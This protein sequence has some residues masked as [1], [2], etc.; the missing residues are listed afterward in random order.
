MEYSFD[1]MITETPRSWISG[2]V[3]YQISPMA[4][5]A[6]PRRKLGIALSVAVERLS[7]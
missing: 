2:M 3:R 5:G 1:V 6:G 4:E 7:M